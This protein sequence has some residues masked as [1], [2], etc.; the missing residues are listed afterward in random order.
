MPEAIYMSSY[1]MLSKSVRERV[2]AG[3][4][5]LVTLGCEFMNLTLDETV[6]TERVYV[7]RGASKLLLGVPTI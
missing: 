5:P 1:G 4:V 3:D 2:G 7:V 6:I